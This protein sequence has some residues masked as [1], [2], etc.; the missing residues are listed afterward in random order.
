MWAVLRALLSLHGSLLK[1]AWADSFPK[2]ISQNHYSKFHFKN[3]DG[4]KGKV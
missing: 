4:S 3:G 1:C 2:S